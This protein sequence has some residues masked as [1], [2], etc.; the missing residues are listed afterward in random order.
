MPKLINTLVL[1]AFHVSNNVQMKPIWVATP[2][3]NFSPSTP[4]PPQGGEV[5]IASPTGSLSVSAEVSVPH[6][7]MG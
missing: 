4:P 2:T 7:V 1:E 5:K 3:K 6:W